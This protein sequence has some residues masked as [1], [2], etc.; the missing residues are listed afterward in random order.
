[1]LGKNINP[2]TSTLPVT[3]RQLRLVFRISVSLNRIMVCSLKKANVH[4]RDLISHHSYLTR[5]YRL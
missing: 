3:T 4:T 5:V 1:M 2:D